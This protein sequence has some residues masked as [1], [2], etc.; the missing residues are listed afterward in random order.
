MFESGFKHSIGGVS[1]V[2]QMRST[3]HSLIFHFYSNISNINWGEAIGEESEKCED[4]LFFGLSICKGSG[5][6]MFSK[7]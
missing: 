4:L 6:R 1:K 5:G 2:A 7:L 3:F